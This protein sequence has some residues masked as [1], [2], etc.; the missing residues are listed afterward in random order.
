MHQHCVW[1]CVSTCDIKVHG[2]RT[3][4]LTVK[5]RSICLF[6][7]FSTLLLSYPV[8]RT[9]AAPKDIEDKLCPGTQSCTI[10]FIPTTELNP[11]YH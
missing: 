6:L 4:T 10:K 5:M 2:P 1:Y 7:I 3:L 8:L 9:S 11:Y